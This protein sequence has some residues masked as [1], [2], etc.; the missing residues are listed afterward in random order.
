[1]GQAQVGKIFGIPIVLDASFILLAV[2]YGASHFLS[3]SMA[4]ISYGIVLVAGIGFSILLHELGH[5]LAGRY[6]RVPTAY[7]EL[8]GLGGLC[9]F[10]RAMPQNRI[11]NIVILLAGP[12]ANFL[13]WK[14]F[15]GL[16][17]ATLSHGADGHDQPERLYFLLM[18][19]SQANL[20][21]GLFNLLPSHP[22]DGGR[23]LVQ[24]VSKAVGYD[25]AMRVVA[26]MGL[27]IS[28]WL[29][30][31]A[32]GGQSF[33][34]LIAFVLFQTNMEILQTHGGPRWRRWN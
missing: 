30:F 19:L 9:H 6:Y 3:G 15:S 24:I 8:N 13:L 32:L 33:A 11:A 18:Q 2:L 34:L 21:L 26:Y 7:I 23:T 14:V 5:A 25:R 16:G 20:M 10:D 12:A 31:L 28:V 27:L 4:R 29:C 17:W 1:M 22:L